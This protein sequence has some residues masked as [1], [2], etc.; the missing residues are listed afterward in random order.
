MAQPPAYNRT[1]DFGADYPDQTDNQA[2]NTELDAVAS[3][4][5][6][7]RTNLAK[8]QRDDGGLRDGI[9][10][11]DSLAAS[12]KDDL[13]NEFSGNINDSVLAAQQ[14]AVEATNAAQAANGDAAT[15]VAARN[16]AVAASTASQSS[17]AAASASQSAAF[18]A[19]TSATASASAASGSASTAGTAA[20]TATS[21]AATAVQAR[22][23][24]VP[25]SATAT[26]KA[27]EALA[28]ATAA[29]TSEDLAEQWAS[30]MDGPVDGVKF[31]AAHY[32]ALAA[33][34]MGLPV[35]FLNDLP[36]SNIGPIAVPT[37]GQME[38]VAARSRYEALQRDHGQCR[39]MYVSSTECRLVPYNGDGLVINGRQYRIPP[40]G[41]A[42]GNT[43]MSV[44]ALHYVYA[45]DNGAGAIALEPWL[46]GSNPHSTHTD[47]VE[48]RTGNPGLTLVGMVLLSSAG[49]F[50]SNLT[51]RWVASWF[52]RQSVALFEPHQA[53]PTSATSYVKLTQ[54]VSSLIWAG[55][56]ARVS[57]TGV[58]YSTGSTGAYLRIQADAAAVAG[59]YGYSLSTSG[60]QEASAIAGNYPASG[61]AVV[62]LAPY[63]YSNNAAVSVT[64]RQ[65]LSAEV[66][67]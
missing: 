37:Q 6:G 12:L 49:L 51:S 14:A 17:A 64:F 15:A 58:V 57:A 63:G 5:N 32:A 29:A 8:I 65:D 52:N 31:S 33:A 22:N 41:V 21:A 61:D 9:V 47:G 23:E 27:A 67:L 38:W 7:I 1:K 34:G 43:G 13:Y 11:K 3:S 44:S 42:L 45:K 28:S 36:T 26:T 59:G 60:N 25:A 62:N 53:S 55:T 39:L 16:D 10:T 2:I 48:I 40:G 66:P 19:A 18:G 35:R 50:V 24:A 30:K 54:G 56:V 46:A 20:T 4:I